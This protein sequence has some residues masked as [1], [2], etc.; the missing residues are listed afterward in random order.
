[1]KSDVV[2]ISSLQVAAQCMNEERG[3]E[4][5]VEDYLIP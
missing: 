1:M 2:N 4:A 5:T 3:P